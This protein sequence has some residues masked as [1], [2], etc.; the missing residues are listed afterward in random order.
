MRLKTFTAETLPR[1]MAM[2]RETLGPDAVILSAQ[3]GI[4]GENARVTAALEN[5]P[6]DEFDFEEV[7]GSAE[8]IDEVTEILDYHRVPIGLV[9]RLIALAALSPSSD[10]I[11]GLATALDDTFRFIDLDSVLGQRPIMLVGMP[12]AG[13]TATSAK[14]CAQA[15]L[16]ERPASIIT[17]DVGKAGGL[18][19]VSTFAEALGAQL[20]EAADI[21]AL[22]AATQSC[23]KEH[24]VVID[25]VGANPFDDDDLDHLVQAAKATKA[26][27]ILVMA[28][29]GD[30]LEA[31]ETAIAF[32]EVGIEQLIATRC[33]VA[34][35]LGGILTAAQAGRLAFAAVTASPSIGDGVTSV[36]P[37][38]LA[39]LLCPAKAT[40]DQ[41]PLAAGAA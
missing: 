6:L 38:S 26:V 29:G 23:P 31:A 22:A 21:A 12:G 9:D 1:A 24:F 39:R 8:A 10:G 5:D 28:A 32:S 17:M 35:R 19:Q 36:N 2:V 30:T 27:P 18:A 37:V 34:R 25:T 14:L 13:K 40:P 20:I 33:D 11:M 15:R 4:D 16:A 7:I 41:Y 3:E